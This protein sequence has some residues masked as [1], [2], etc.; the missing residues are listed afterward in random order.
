VLDVLRTQVAPGNF[1]TWLQPTRLQRHDGT[2]LEV[3]VPNEMFA[4]WLDSRYSSAIR[5]ALPR[6][7]LDGHRVRFV[8]ADHLVASHP[9][10][11][12]STPEPAAPRAPALST[13]PVSPHR[14]QRLNPRY[15]FD[16]FVVSSCNHFAHAAALRVSD[17]VGTAYNPLFIHGGVGL[18][19]T[20]LM[21]AIGNKLSSLRPDIVITYKTTE[22]FMNELINAIR[23]EKTPQ[24]RELYRSVDVLMLD[25][26]QFLE[27]KNATQEELFHTFNAL[28]DSGKQIILT[29]DR[30]PRSISALEERLRTRFEWGLI[31]D[32]Q[33]PDLETKVAILNKMAASKGWLLPSEVALLIATHVNSNIRELE[34]VLTTV[35][36]AA[37]MR[38]QRHPDLAIAR[39]ILRTV[40]K[41]EEARPTIEA[42]TRVVARHFDLR[43]ADLKSK[44]NK[45]RIAFPRQIAMYLTRQL[46]TESYQGIG[47]FF[48]GKHH[49]TV[50]HAERKIAELRD[51]DSSVSRLLG[52]IEEK[53]R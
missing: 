14:R 50:L 34:G 12:P 32:I 15:T 52:E 33:P 47:N 6:V 25:D 37:S 18:G 48:D 19:K 35:S 44:T 8:Y 53:L 26:V 45:R 41:H 7:G 39:E 4:E 27:Q 9:E 43:V 3:R 17:D 5:S 20:H 10:P 22:A 11:G 16:H 49:T 31:A 1:E 28:Y 42:I 46:S 51:S 36:A 13:A 40:T 29:S 24:F 2:T 30:P 38:G 21:Q 23:F